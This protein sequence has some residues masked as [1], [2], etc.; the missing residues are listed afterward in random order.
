MTYKEL[1]DFIRRM[2]DRSRDVYD[3]T[4]DEKM[5]F[6]FSD[7]VGALSVVSKVIH[8]WYH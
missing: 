2:A 7:S 6:H 1:Y 3:I 8:P 5:L 4:K